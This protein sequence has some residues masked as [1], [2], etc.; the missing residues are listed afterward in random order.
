V[1]TTTISGLSIFMRFET[2]FKEQ[3]YSFFDNL[4]IEKVKKNIFL[5]KSGFT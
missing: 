1:Y 3:L 4:A 2:P 5:K